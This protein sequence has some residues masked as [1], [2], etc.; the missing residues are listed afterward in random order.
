[1][2]RKYKNHLQA[3][4]ASATLFVE[5]TFIGPSRKQ[6]RNAANFIDQNRGHLVT[7][8]KVWILLS[9]QIY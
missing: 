2:V 4:L 9:L 6:Q 1:M 5:G 7:N 3:L 8:W